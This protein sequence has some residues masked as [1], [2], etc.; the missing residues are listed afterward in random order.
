[1]LIFSSFFNISGFQHFSFPNARFVYAQRSF[2]SKASKTSS[3][4]CLLSKGQNG[5]LAPT[6]CTF[7]KNDALASATCSCSVS[8]PPFLQ[9]GVLATFSTFMTC[10]F[11]LDIRHRETLARNMSTPLKDFG[12]FRA[13]LPLIATRMLRF[14]IFWSLLGPVGAF[15]GVLAALWGLP[16]AASCLLEASGA[17]QLGLNAQENT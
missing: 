1:M 12:H 13:S 10:A 15:W 2:W 11:L 16:G 3:V 4:F 5:A 8:Q 17:L 9:N 7:S 14:R 6:V